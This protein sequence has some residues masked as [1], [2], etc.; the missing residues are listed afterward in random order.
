MAL[1]T[2]TI[3]DSADAYSQ[4]FCTT[5]TVAGDSAYPTG[6]TAS[7]GAFMRTALAA[8]L[9]GDINVVCAFGHAAGYVAFYD[10]ANDKLIVQTDA[11]VQVTDTTDLSA[12][13]FYITVFYK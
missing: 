8:Q 7:F 3:R 13:T 4:L 11:L 10:A 12:V 5:L 2:P 1:G 9:K 6:G